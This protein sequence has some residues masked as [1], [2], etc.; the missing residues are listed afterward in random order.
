MS[1]KPYRVVSSAEERLMPCEICN[2]PLSAKH[3]LLQFHEYGENAKTMRLCANCHDLYHVTYQALRRLSRTRALLERGKGYS[4]VTKAQ[5]IWLD[6]AWNSLK[7]NEAFIKIEDIVR[8]MIALEDEAKR[9]KFENQIIKMRSSDGQVCF[10]RF[11][12]RPNR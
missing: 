10:C 12:L 4:V 1:E 8:E 3:H 9:I 11:V 7:D 5:E 2:H 6:L